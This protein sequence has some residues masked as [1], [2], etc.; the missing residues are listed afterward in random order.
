MT[1]NPKKKVKWLLKKAK[2]AT[3]LPK[4]ATVK[5]KYVEN[6]A[7]KMSKSMTKPERIFFKIC[8]ELKIKCETQK[9]VGGKIFDFFLPETNTLVEID[10]SYWHGE[11]LSLN[12][13][14]GV[15]KKAVK[16]DKQKDIIAVGYGYGIF[17]VWESELANNYEGVK[18]KIKEKF[19]N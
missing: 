1:F 8:K 19:L 12:E 6:Q 10:G 9:I 7:K 13:M 15:Q 14:N 17:R 11:G 3:K 18:N 2:E 16:N 5:K 4:T